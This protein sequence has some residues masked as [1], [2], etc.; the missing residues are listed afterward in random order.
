MIGY[1]SAHKDGPCQDNSETCPPPNSFPSSS[2]TSHGCGSAWS[3]LS[4]FGY[5]SRDAKTTSLAPSQTTPHPPTIT[6]ENPPPAMSTAMD[7]ISKTPIP[8]TTPTITAI[9]T[10]IPMVPTTTAVPTTT[11]ET[12]PTAVP[13]IPTM[14]VTTTVVP[15]TT[16]TV[17]PTTTMGTTQAMQMEKSR[18]PGR[19]HKENRCLPKPW[20]QMGHCRAVLCAKT[21]RRMQSRPPCVLTKKAPACR[22]R[23]CAPT[24]SPW[25]KAVSK[26]TV[27]TCSCAV[28][29][30]IRCLRANHTSTISPTNP[31]STRVIFLSSNSWDTTLHCVSP[32]RSPTGIS[33]TRPIATDCSSSPLFPC[34]GPQ[35]SKKIVAHYKPSFGNN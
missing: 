31:A 18:C 25:D 23:S 5:P 12:I 21:V 22:A 28:W 14:E 15:T 17:V 29:C 34:G 16:T 1:R 6:R 9:Q 10:Q 8:P 32:V 33:C 30:T 19:D 27:K 3:F 13:T 4:S 26:S 35:T 24:K 11:T 2:H 7:K 20:D